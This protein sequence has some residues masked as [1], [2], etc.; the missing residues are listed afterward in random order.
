MLVFVLTAGCVCGHLGYNVVRVIDGDTIVVQD[1]V[2]GIRTHIRLAGYDAPERGEP[3]FDEATARMK[4]L[5]E[6]KW[7]RVVPLKRGAYGRLVARVIIEG[8]QDLT[9]AMT[10]WQPGAAMP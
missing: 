6:G 10:E 3:G 9:E 1:R 8:A 7:V 2:N 4:A 5:V